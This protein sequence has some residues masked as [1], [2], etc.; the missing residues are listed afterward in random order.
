MLYKA[1]SV[2]DNKAMMFNAPFFMPHVGMAIRALTDLVNDPSTSISRHPAD[3]TLIE[4]GT[5]D[6]ETGVLSAAPHQAHVTAQ[7]LLRRLPLQEGMLNLELDGEKVLPASER[8]EK[9]I[10]SREV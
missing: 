8:A 1:F 2:Y 6:D 4:I 5:Y 9:R 7:Q 10:G 3:Y